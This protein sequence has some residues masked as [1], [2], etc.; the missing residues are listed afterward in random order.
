[1]FGYVKEITKEIAEAA[2]KWWADQI[3]GNV[4]FDNGDDSLTGSM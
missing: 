3:S 1:M 2:A 4:I